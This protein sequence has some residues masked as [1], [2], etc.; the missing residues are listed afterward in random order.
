MQLKKDRLYSLLPQQQSLEAP[1][2]QGY[3]PQKVL[4]LTPRLIISKYVQTAST[5]QPKL[6]PSTGSPTT[7]LG[8]L[9]QDVT[10]RSHLQFVMSKEH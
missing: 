1:E 6:I 3:K 9:Q 4:S 2:K 8:P 7:A 5:P 10:T